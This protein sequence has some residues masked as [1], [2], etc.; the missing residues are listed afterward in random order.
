[1]LPGATPA[2]DAESAEPQDLPAPVRPGTA[3]VFLHG[4]N[5]GTCRDFA[6]QLA[7]E[8]AAIGCDTEVAPLDAYAGGL[9][10]DRPVVITAASYNG[11]PTDDATAFAARLEETHDLSGVTYAVLG[12]GDRNWA[13][14]YQHVPTRIDERLAASGAGRLL[15]RA[16][17]DASGD[18]TGT[19]RAFTAS[20][21]GALLERYGDPDA[22][23]PEPEPATA[24]EV[25][26]VTGGPLD[27]LA[28]RHALVPMRVTEAR[29]L[30][31]PGY[32]RRKRFVRVALPD[33]VT[34][35]TA[36][37]LTV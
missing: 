5:Y 16:A 25:R 32:A 6:A 31:A 1:P 20:L 15:E 18:L 29:D 24:Y 21:R 11:R 26:T 35:R 27:A 2:Q 37:H 23:T 10:T 12:V 34:Y 9:P 3:A 19:V 28:E 33:G 30:T 7:D 4:S 13:A 17:A 8:A 22:T 14:T 36:D